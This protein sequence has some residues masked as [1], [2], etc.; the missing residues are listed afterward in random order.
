MSCALYLSVPVPGASLTSVSIYP[1][2]TY[3]F[4]Q[5]LESGL[6]ETW[7]VPSVFS[8]AFVALGTFLPEQ[9]PDAS[10]F[11]SSRTVSDSFLH[12]QA[13]SVDNNNSQVSQY[14]Y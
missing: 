14:S 3:A 12:S 7:Y 5:K 1:Q 11:K 4:Q 13:Y 2:V 9:F 10:N 8:R 6:T